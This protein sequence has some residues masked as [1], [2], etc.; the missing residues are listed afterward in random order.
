MD[1]HVHDAAALRP[2]L[3]AIGAL[4]EDLAG[5]IAVLARIRVDD[6]ADGAV[7][8]RHLRLDPAPA[9]SVARDHDL[10]LH[11]DAELRQLLVVLRR[12][13]VHVNELRGHVAVSGVGVE[14]W[15]GPCVRRVGILRHCRL[16]ELQHLA[17]RGDELQDTLGGVRHQR[18]ECL[19]R[20]VQAPRL[21]LRQHVLGDLLAAR[22]AGVVRLRGDDAHVLP[23]VLR[24]RDGAELLLDLALDVAARRRESTDRG[25]ELRPDGGRNEEEADGCGQGASD[26]AATIP[27]S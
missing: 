9:P 22:A 5:E 7:F 2:H 16:R 11:V 20:R 27:S 26:H 1:R 8:G 19:D 17:H 15:Q 21:E 3:R 18:F 24:L 6:A 14:R 12:P 4:R 13:V 25:P 23:V 10:P